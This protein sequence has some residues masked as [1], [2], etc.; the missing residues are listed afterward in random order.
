MEREINPLKKEGVITLVQLSEWA[1]P[2]VPV[3]K[4]DG[5]IRICGD[6]KITVNRV[7]KVD[8]YIHTIPY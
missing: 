2:V 5:F 4:N 1:A 8:T 3:V 7:E 6:Y